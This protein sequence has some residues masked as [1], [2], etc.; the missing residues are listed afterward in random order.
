MRILIVDKSVIP[1]FLYGG[2]ERVIWSLGH[3]LTKMGHQVTFLVNENSHCDFASVIHINHELPILEQIKD[4]YDVVHFNFRP[5]DIE[6]FKLPYI[7]TVHG[8]TNSLEEF[9]INSV[10]VSQ[11]HAFRY[12]SDSYVHNGLD[13]NEYAAPNFD[14]K[15]NYYHFLGNAA[16][17]VKNVVGAIDVIKSTKK[18][19]LKVLGGVR[20]NINMGIRLTF[21]PRISFSGKVGGEKKYNLLNGSKGLIFPVR[22][23]EPFGLAIIES[24][25]NG[26]PVFGT[27]YGSLPEL[28]SEEVG[29]L[30]NNKDELSEA[31]LNTEKYSPQRC[32]E[33]AKEHFNSKKMAV[34]YLIKYETVISSQKLN[35]TPPKL[36]VQSTSKFLDWN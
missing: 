33:Y 12:N 5:K 19:K 6:S 11:N 24:L 3:E 28:V 34:S 1:V 4:D 23:H 13:W 30:S 26:C 25:Y 32:H 10:F 35:A 20:F 15:R 29:F 18:E 9:D 21:S 31:I 7:I 36:K 17:R 2:T 22:W 8:N 14:V 16:W 27:P